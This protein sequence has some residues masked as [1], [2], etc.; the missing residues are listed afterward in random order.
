[1]KVD[2]SKA[3]VSESKV[4]NDESFQVTTM[5]VLRAHGAQGYLSVPCN[6]VV[7]NLMMIFMAIALDLTT[8]FMAI[9]LDLMV[10]C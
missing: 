3:R 2:E 5:R 10:I 7:S 1:M 6:V 9:T 8:I 4:R